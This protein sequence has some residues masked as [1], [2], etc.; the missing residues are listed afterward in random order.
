MKKKA[1]VSDEEFDELEQIAEVQA[2][3]VEEIVRRSVAEYLVKSG[4]GPAFEPVGFGMWAHRH[5][6]QDASAWVHE[7]RRSR[8]LAHSIPNLSLKYSE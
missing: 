8:A 3:P 2:L 6:M 4:A 5:E 1:I 7:L